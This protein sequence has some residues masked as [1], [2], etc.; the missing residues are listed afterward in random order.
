MKVVHLVAAKK[1]MEALQV[2]AKACDKKLVEEHT[3]KETA[4]RK[5]A[6]DTADTRWAQDFARR[7]VS[8]KDGGFNFKSL[9]HFFNVLRDSN[10]SLPLTNYVQCHDPQH[11]AGMFKPWLEAKEKFI[12]T[13]MASERVVQS[14]LS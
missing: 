3:T 11:A 12:S 14:K 6:Q 8:N 1:Q 10:I 7:I 4:E 9:D 13:E 5:A 2:E